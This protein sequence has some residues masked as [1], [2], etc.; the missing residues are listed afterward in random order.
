MKLNRNAAYA[1]FLL[2]ALLATGCVNREA[3]RQAKETEAI[4]SDPA[5]PVQTQPVTVRT[6]RETVDLTGSVTTGEDV[7][8]GAKISGKLVAV[9]VKDGDFVSAG[10][11]LAVQD[12]SILQPQLRQ[13]LAQV[14][15]AEANLSQVLKRSSETPVL[16]SAG[17]AQ[18]EAQLKAAEAGLRSAQAAYA[19][20]RAGARIEERKQAEAAVESAKT[21][22]E[23]AQKDLERTRTLVSQGA[24]A[25]SRLDGALNAY[26]AAVSQYQQAVQ[27]LEI[28]RNGARV[29]DLRVAEEGVR[30][31]E[32][33][34]AQAKEG[35]RNAQANKRLDSTTLDQIGAARAQV[36]AA[37]AQADLIRQNIAD[38][39]IRAP[40][41]GKVSGR[42]A[43]IGTVLGPG[44]PVLRL[45]GGEGA[46]FEAEVPETVIAK[47]RPG[48][49]VTI[50]MN[51]LPGRTF[52][53]RVA[54]VGPIGSSVGRIFT[55]R[56]RF[57]GDTAEIK[58]GMFASAR[59]VL[60]EVANAETVP[61]TAVVSRGGKSVVYVLEGTDQVREVPVTVGVRDGS[62]VQ[63][64]GVPAGAQVVVR[65]QTNLNATSRVK[66]EK[67]VSGTSAPEK[68]A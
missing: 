14:A 5:V 34:V 4:V 38:A 44:S 19:K 49:S 68:G 29:E 28:I 24:L 32:A 43:Q 21:N 11:A 7:Q 42:P 57:L 10:Q 18:A 23:T 61:F 36:A 30:Q 9:Y 55:V 12:T 67:P 1:A 64:A 17:V 65:G 22:M 60:D 20:A 50:R 56:I 3:Q 48:A 35:L 47:V 59:L 54:A 66:L 53:G 37:R 26:Q 62:F 41:A 45:I 25:Q 58:P 6:I 8:V 33:S 2:S 39:T 52:A 15:S 51:A 63:V 46:Y 27:A 31:A 13:A 40:F 16:S